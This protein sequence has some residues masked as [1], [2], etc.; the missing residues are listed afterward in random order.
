MDP[1]SAYDQQRVMV[2]T[3]IFE[4]LCMK[5]KE[6]EV[7]VVGI[8]GMIERKIDVRDMCLFIMIL[9]C[10]DIDTWIQ[11]YSQVYEKEDKILSL[12]VISHILTLMFQST[13]YIQ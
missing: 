1:Q 5:P 13:V 4:L 6:M 11:A 7:Q 9:L 12:S 10:D 8:S 3:D 2:I